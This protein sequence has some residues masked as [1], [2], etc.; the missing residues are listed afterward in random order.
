MTNEE[1]IWSSVV[2]AIWVVLMT[3]LIMNC[4]TEKRLCITKY[5]PSYCLEI[6]KR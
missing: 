1:K 5:N 4:G 6:L 2:L 3:A